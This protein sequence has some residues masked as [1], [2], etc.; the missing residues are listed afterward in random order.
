MR[1]QKVLDFLNEK[2]IRSPSETKTSILPQTCHQKLENV[3]ATL[4][5]KQKNKNEPHAAGE[6]DFW[7]LQHPKRENVIFAENEGVWKSILLFSLR[8]DGRPGAVTDWFSLKMIIC[9]QDFK[10]V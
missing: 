1:S 8:N 7:F 10:K 5:E 3:N 4:G 6:S 2:Q 9:D